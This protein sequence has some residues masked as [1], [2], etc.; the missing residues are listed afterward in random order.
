MTFKLA[1]EEAIYAAAPDVAAIEVEGVA[2]APAADPSTCDV[3]A[4]GWET[5][6]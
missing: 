2:A 1:I 3:T 5:R 4:F 6:R